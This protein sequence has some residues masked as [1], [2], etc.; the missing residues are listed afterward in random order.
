V[1]ASSQSTKPS[2]EGSRAK[3]SVPVASSPDV[4]G[5]QCGLDDQTR[6]ICRHIK[7]KHYCKLLGS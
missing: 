3:P 1:T 2:S 5:R 6:T 4:A 7:S